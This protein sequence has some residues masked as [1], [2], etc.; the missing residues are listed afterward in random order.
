M[1]DKFIDSI[2]TLGKFGIENSRYTRDEKE[3]AKSGVDCLSSVMKLMQTHPNQDI[4]V[5]GLSLEQ[6]RTIKQ[7]AEQCNIEKVV[8]FPYPNGRNIVPL[9]RVYGVD[10]E[11]FFRS[12]GWTRL[13]SNT[14]LGF[15]SE[16][17]GLEKEYGIVLYESI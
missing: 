5:M 15:S 10:N 13:Q 9:V 8:L 12:L 1:N 17:D 7:V 16:C 3:W 14:Q 2:A 11:R 6:I 4:F